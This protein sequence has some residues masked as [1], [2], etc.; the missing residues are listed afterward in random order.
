MRCKGM[1]REPVRRKDKTG[2][3]FLTG[4]VNK[5]CG[6]QATVF[7]RVRYSE[8]YSYAD[9]GVHE[10][11]IGFCDKCAEGKD[12][13]DAYNY[14]ASK[15]QP[16]QVLRVRGIVSEVFPDD[17][18][19]VSDEARTLRLHDGK[20]E[21]LKIMSYKGNQDLADDWQE[22]FKLAWEEFQVRT[23]MLK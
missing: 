12:K 8:L 1:K 19:T 17:G 21:L 20:R 3:T 11:V 22:A 18:S 13:P 2:T 6:R 9:N 10:D 5:N 4:P 23:V 15:R 14:S 7:F 16:R